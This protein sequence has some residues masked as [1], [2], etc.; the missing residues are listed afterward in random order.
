MSKSSSAP[1]FRSGSGPLIAVVL[2]EN[3]SVDG[4][5]YE[6]PKSLFRALAGAGAFPLAIPY[7]P[8]REGE[9]ISAFDGLVAPGGRFAFPAKWYPDV[10]S[11][12]PQSERLPFELALMEGFLAARKPVLGICSGMQMLAGLAG[13]RLSGAIGKSNPEALKHNGKDLTHAVDVEPGTRLADITGAT[14][15]EVNTLHNEAVIEAA[16][17]LAV[18][19]YAPDGTIEAIELQGHPFALGVQ[20]HQEKY[21]GQNHPGNAL[22]SAF[23]RAASQ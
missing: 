14:R 22:F 20:W 12:A 9:I 7:V 8:G 13:A 19:A 11:R 18:S 16:P 2:D 1:S 21:D 17:G 3:T 6:S 15:F 4:T 10:T 5:T 23:V